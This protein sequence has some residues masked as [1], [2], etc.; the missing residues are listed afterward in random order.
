LEAH[1]A[2]AGI[3]GRKQVAGQHHHF[4]RRAMIAGM[5]NLVN[6]GFAHRIA[7]AAGLARRIAAAMPAS[8]AASLLRS[9]QAHYATA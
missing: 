5:A 1:H 7:G 6:A 2:L 4:M 9:R 3:A 8:L